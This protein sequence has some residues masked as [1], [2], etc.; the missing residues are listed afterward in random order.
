VRLRSLA[1]VALLLAALSACSANNKTQL[2]TTI[3]NHR[4]FTMEPAPL[5]SPP[6]KWSQSD[7]LATIRKGDPDGSKT[8]AWFGYYQ[9][10]P[11]WLAITNGAQL[12][13][14]APAG[15]SVPT[16]GFRLAVFADG[17]IPAQLLTEVDAAGTAPRPNVLP[18]RPKRYDG[19]LH[20]TYITP[21]VAQVAATP[22]KWMIEPAPRRT[23]PLMAR[24]DAEARSHAIGVNQVDA[25]S[26]RVYFGLFTGQDVPGAV[27]GRTPAWLV[28]GT[29]LR[30]LSE[31]PGKLPQF[32]YGVTAFSDDI[33]QP[34][35][36][37]RVQLVEPP[38]AY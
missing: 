9:G 21:G 15:A 22:Q 38:L 36:S 30:I 10:K 5:G 18:P 27:H 4:G 35:V 29:H 16:R 34:W 17:V 14:P 24:V 6:P 25:R 37:G 28:V 19:R 8:H 12:A 23:R 2:L 32:G 3:Y 33:T 13:I 20:V 11:A 31:G 1:L 26:T 7:A